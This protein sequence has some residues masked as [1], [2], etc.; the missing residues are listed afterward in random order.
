MNKKLFLLIFICNIYLCFS[1][2]EI[3][4]SRVSLN[5]NQ[6]KIIKTKLNEFSTLSIDFA[7]INK[8]FQKQDSIFSLEFLLFNNETIQIEVYKR[9][10][11]STDYNLSFSG[12]LASKE[13]KQSNKKIATYWGTTKNEGYVRLTLDNDFIYGMIENNGEVYIINQLKYFLRDNSIAANQLIVYKTKD[14]LENNIY[15]DNNYESKEMVEINSIP[16][17]TNSCLTLEVAIDADFE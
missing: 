4:F 7:K 5:E 11:R 16:S 6:Q 10:I 3:T 15:C 9:D 13:E 17:N 14:I 12:K 1:Q 8:Y 2:E